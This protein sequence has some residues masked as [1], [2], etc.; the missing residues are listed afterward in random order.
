MWAS[1]S[2]PKPATRKGTSLLGV[3]HGVGADGHTSTHSQKPQL[4]HL[5]PQR[6]AE[7][8]STD[9]KLSPLFWSTSL[10]GIAARSSPLLVLLLSSES[11]TF[12]TFS[13]GANLSVLLL[14]S[15]ATR[16]SFCLCFWRKVRWILWAASTRVSFERWE[17]LCAMLF[18]RCRAS[19]SCFRSR[20]SSC[21]TCAIGCSSISASLTCSIPLSWVEITKLRYS[22]ATRCTR[23][24]VF[25]LS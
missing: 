22:S 10:M 16:N 24:I 11:S 15:T 14:L 18:S 2:T 1:M 4:R 21:I 12:S 9:R 17:V 13:V 7:C 5:P 23:H 8:G 19:L 25:T 3:S 20:R 6:F